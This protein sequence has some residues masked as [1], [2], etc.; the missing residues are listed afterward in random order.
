MD[1]LKKGGI[2]AFN[3]HKTAEKLRKMGLDVVFG[4][5]IWPQQL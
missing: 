3:Q 5:E 2:R 4:T 1:I